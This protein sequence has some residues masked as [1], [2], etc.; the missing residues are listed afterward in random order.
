MHESLSREMRSLN[1]EIE[2]I[3][4]NQVEKR[5]ICKYKMLTQSRINTENPT[6][7]RTIMRSTESSDK[8]QEENSIVHREGQ[9]S[10]NRLLLI[11]NCG[12]LRRMGQNLSSMKEKQLSTHNSIS[13]DK[14]IQECK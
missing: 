12:V 9:Q 14:I 6:S 2:T 13:S 1:R 4:K 3:K 8:D 11:R 5:Q 7:T 10:I